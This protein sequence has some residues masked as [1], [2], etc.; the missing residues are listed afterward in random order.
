MLA[1]ASTLNLGARLTSGAA[2]L[3]LAILT[4]NLLDTHGRGLYAVITTW[5]GIVATMITAGTPVTAADL[6]HQRHSEQ[7]LHGAITVIALAAGAIVI[8]VSALT[9]VWTGSSTF[10]AL[11]GAGAITVLVPYAFYEMVLAQARGDVLLVSATDVGL[12]TC[13]LLATAAVAVVLE[14]TVTTLVL[15]AAA[16]ALV[17]AGA[18]FARS[19]RNGSL[20][21]RRGAPIAWSIARRSLGVVVVGGATLLCTRIDVLVVAAVISASAAGVYSIPVALAASAMLLSRAVLT[22]AYHPIMTAPAHELPRRLGAALRHSVILVAV[23][24]GMSIPVVAVGAGPVFGAAYRGVWVPYAI[25]ILAS[26]FLCVAEL[27]SHVLL[28]R[29]ERQRE[30]V[31]ISIGM[32]VVNGVLAAAGA[33]WLGLVGAAASSVVAYAFAAYAGLT[34]CAREMSVPVAELIAPRRSDL[35]LYAGLL[36]SAWAHGRTTG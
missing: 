17:P 18:H 24:G 35:G 22:A 26:V 15:A 10:G 33:A 4:T 14:P 19:L 5:T 1:R 36:R 8:P 2:T 30:L 7:A 13:P 31:L 34:V 21:L 25:L 28:T 11:L 9:A 27:I 16:G 29:L 3:G 32:L 6:I 23:G 12:A 20:M